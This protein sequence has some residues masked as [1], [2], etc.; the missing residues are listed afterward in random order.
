MPKAIKIG[1]KLVG[2]GQ[3]VFIIAEAGVN[4]NGKFALAKKLIDVAADAGADAV[5]FQTFRAEQVVTAGG[6]MAKYQK[7]N[8]G[9]I[10]S[11]Q[12]MLR[13]LELPEKYYP[14]LISHARRR[15]IIFISTPHGAFASA[16]FL[17][18]LHVPAY[19]IG[20][21]D[22]TALPFLSYVAKFGKPIIIS[23]GMATLAEARDAVATI[24]KTG[25]KKIIV[26]HCT[27]NYP[28]ENNEANLQAMSEL[29]KL[30]TLVGYSDHTIGNTAA[31]T[32]VTLGAVMLERHFTISRKLP[33]PDQKA[34]LEPNELAEYVR[35]VKSVPIILGDGKKRP[36]KSERQYIPLTRR[37]IVSAQ[38]IKKWERISARHLTLKRPGTGLAP[39]LWGKVIGR[40]AARDISADT[41]ITLNMLK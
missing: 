4:H 13:K 7:E 9:I 37:S 2:E 15:G 24:K 8:L 10:E 23:T 35:A 38:P 30:N 29:Q 28:T 16:D 34:S 22:L 3:P 1:S 41:L 21:G 39:K 5:K 31:I 25:N 36:Q 12:E 40:R 14:A 26:F 32:A 17:R 18:N 19:K 20:S 6:K 33:G 27:T 11:Q